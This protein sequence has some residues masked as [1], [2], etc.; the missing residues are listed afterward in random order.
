MTGLLMLKLIHLACASTWFGA[1]WLAAGD[2][3]RT[4]ALGRPYADALP[5]R[6]FRLE[7]L[8]ITCGVT[9][10]LTG[11]GLA[12]WIYGPWALPVRIYAVT[13]LTLASMF[14]GALLV[15]PAW[16]RVAVVIERGQ[17]LELACRSAV[18]FGRSLW[19][20][21][22]LLLASL[23]VIVGKDAGV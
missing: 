15:S 10:L 21:R 23:V 7:R 1:S 6:I 22:G 17:D 11:L 12:G 16:R 2:V 20:E 5:E 14:V 4:L 3:R 19:L 13:G 18:Q 9:T 8:A